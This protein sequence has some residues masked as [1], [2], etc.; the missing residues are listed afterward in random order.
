M[1]IEKILGNTRQNAEEADFGL[2]NLWDLKESYLCRGEKLGVISP[3]PFGCCV[4]ETRQ[5]EG[6]TKED[7][8]G[9][10]FKIRYKAVCGMIAAQRCHF[11]R[12]YLPPLYNPNLSVCSL[13][14]VGC[15]W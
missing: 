15:L 3:H 13:T 11:M 12:N 2:L 14:P 7:D 8:A 6:N 4:K 5:L 1:Q 10:S 9:T